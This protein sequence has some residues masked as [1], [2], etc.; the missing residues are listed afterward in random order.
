MKTPKEI[1]EILHSIRDVKL[2]NDEIWVKFE[3]ESTTFKDG[4]EPNDGF[5]YNSFTQELL[6]LI[7]YELR[8]K[9]AE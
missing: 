5:K 8:G 1:L 7:E 3:P 9:L 4:W 6:L 2:E